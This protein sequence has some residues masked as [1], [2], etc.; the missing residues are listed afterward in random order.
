MM[1]AT[2]KVLLPARQD[3]LHFLSGLLLHGG[4][5]VCVDVGG[6]FDIAVTEQ[7]EDTEVTSRALTTAA[8]WM[9][10]LVITKKA[11]GWRRVATCF[12]PGSNGSRSLVKSSPRFCRTPITKRLIG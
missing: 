1:T 11:L 4:Q 6:G 8:D 5:E 10:R 2:G 9:A 3:R 12:S 7:A